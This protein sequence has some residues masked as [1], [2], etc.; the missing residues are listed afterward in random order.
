MPSR[1]RR[2]RA[3]PQH[4]A[5]RAH[6]GR[7]PRHA[8]ARPLRSSRAQSRPGAAKSSP[9]RGSS[10]SAWPC[11]DS[12]ARRTA[13]CATRRTCAGST[14]PLRDLVADATGLP[15]VV[16][17]DAMLGALA[18]HLFGAARGIDDVV[19]LNGGAS[20]IGGGLIIGGM[21]VAGAG[22]Y[23]GEFGQNRPGIAAA[24]DRRA[25][26]GVLED[27]VS[28]ARLLAAVELLSA[29]EPTLADA[30]RASTSVTAA[31][32]LARQRRILATALG[33]CRQRAQSLGRRPRRLPRHAG[34]ARPGRAGRGGGSRRRCRPA[35]RASAS[36]PPFWPRTVC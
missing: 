21:P 23:S 32:E 7:P 6:R 3:G 16:G 10:A 5:A 24:S 27:E 14:S 31:E 1:S 19:Y 15:T 34:R 36:A 30:L 29:D 13:S 4:P 9:T 25:G 22:G 8:R 26:D 12:S 17:N 35:W 2:D 28:R 11:R 33:Q 20:G 18:E